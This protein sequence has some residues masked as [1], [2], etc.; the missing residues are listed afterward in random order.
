MAGSTYVQASA[1]SLTDEQSQA[2]LALVEQ[3]FADG[4]RVSDERQSHMAEPMGTAVSWSAPSSEQ[5]YVGVELGDAT[6]AGV[7]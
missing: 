7:T 4:M 1:P 6:E 5:P 2:T 3:A